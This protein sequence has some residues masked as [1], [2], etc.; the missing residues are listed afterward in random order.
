MAATIKIPTIFTA[1]DKF[2][3]IIDQ[4][5]KKTSGLQQKL[6]GLE[7]SNKKLND[8]KYHA[9]AGAAA[10]GL[11]VKNANDFESSMSNVATLIDINNESMTDMSK[12]VIDISKR[13][14]VP[15]SE[16][17][18]S[19]YDIRS[20]GI[21]A[22]K[23]MDTL[24]TSARLSVAG[25]STVSEATNIQT[26]AMNA[27]S[28]ENLTADQIANIL[29]KTVKAGKTTISQLSQAFG[30]NAAIVESSGVKL[31]DFQAATAAL[32]LSGMPAAQA[33]NQIKASMIQLKKPTEEMIKIYRA[34]GVETGEELIKKKGGMVAAMQAIND[35]GTKM[36]LNLSKAWS[37]S[38]ALGAVN[39]LTGSAK[40]AYLSTLKDMASGTDVLS[41]A[42]NKQSKTQ[43]SQ[44][45]LA[46]NNMQALSITIGTKLAPMITQLTN[47]FTPLIQSITDFI[48]KNDWII[49]ILPVLIG[50]FIAFKAV[51]WAS[52]AAMVANSIIM[53]LN[54]ATIGAMSLAMKGNVIAQTAFKIAM[55]IGT[56]ATWVA[57]VAQTAFAIAVNASLWPILLVVAAVAAVVA[58]IMNWSKITDWFG[59]KWSQFTSWI[60]ETWQK[61][62]AFFK[63]FDFK[64][65]FIG[66]GQAIISYMLLPLKTVLFLL[67]KVPG[68]VGELSKMGLDKINE[69]TG[70]V[71]VKSDK[72]EVLPST[73]QASSETVKKTIKESNLNINIKDKGN[74][75]ESVKRDSSE[76]PVRV[77]NTVGDF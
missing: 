32:T 34:L 44:L 24:E 74:N 33:Q 28:K 14:P 40:E 41:E 36:G 38:E 68:K 58:I 52:R 66:I 39:A 73:N 55:G 62:V 3:A 17:T 50:L 9:L 71:E 43:A 35:Q 59:Q 10:I 49:N 37:S 69:I 31:M 5:T 51:L 13:M 61:V 75:V 67:S 2:S 42:F 65:M 1:Q 53:G 21:S 22:S 45:K 25:L 57:T 72:N 15:I 29:F 30:A 77:S 63:E 26:S 60:S 47:A 19:L 64:A 8:L 11:S 16:L 76:I 48:S 46:Q 56:A 70:N 18:A 12:N 54:A 4:M 27:F 20:A 6:S 7:R 23:S